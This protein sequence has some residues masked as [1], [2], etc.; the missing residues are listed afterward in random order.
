MSDAREHLTT[1][2][3][4][5]LDADGYRAL[6]SDWPSEDRGH[7]RIEIVASDGACADC[8]VPKDML[9]L[10]LARETPPGIEIDEADLVYPGDRDGQN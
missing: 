4:Q 6:V 8:L 10:V 5:M 9:R 2:L 7:P 1:L 3:S